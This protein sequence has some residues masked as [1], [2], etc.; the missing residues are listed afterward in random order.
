MTPLTDLGVQLT[1]TQ[2]IA[3]APHQAQAITGVGLSLKLTLATAACLV[4]ATASQTRPDDVR[5]ATFILGLAMIIGSFGEFF[6]YTFRGLQRVELDAALTLLTRTLTVVVGFWL[7]GAGL[8]LAGVAVAY[9][10]GSL[11]GA[12]GGWLWLRHRF[13]IPTLSFR[14]EIWSEVVR[15]A[16]PLGAA[17]VLSVAYTRTA[18]FVLDALEGPDAVGTYGV[19]LKLTEPLAILPAALLA[20]VFPAIVRRRADGD[21]AGERLRSLTT[22]VLAGCSSPPS[23]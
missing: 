12:A 20:A 9:L 11:A 6:G 22:L 4:L 7:L 16:I 13:F 18:V 2:Q 14:P 17:I 19:A 3:R 15:R 10:A 8:G 23:A 21:P 1:M 5:A